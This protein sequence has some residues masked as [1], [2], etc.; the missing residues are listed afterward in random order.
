MLRSG[1]LDWIAA[2][3]FMLPV[4]AGCSA[5]RRADTVMGDVN[6]FGWLNEE[7]VTFDNA[8]TVS[9]R[10]VSLVLRCGSDLDTDRL[11]LTL[12]FMAPDSSR[13]VERRVF[14][15]HLPE[16]SA[17]TAAVVTIPYRW[18]VVLR[19]RGTYTIA[20]KPAETV[21]G[22]EAAGFTFQKTE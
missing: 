2:A 4:L 6:P 20:I 3:V 10:D 15:L 1:V 19:Q 8:D 17:S 21:R 18:S 9:K 11:P 5:E 22:I 14:A 13:F 12:T 7:V 16:K